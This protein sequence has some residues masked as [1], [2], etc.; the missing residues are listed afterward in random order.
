[1]KGARGGRGIRPPVTRPP[2][3]L[4]RGFDPD[5]PTADPG[6]GWSSSPRGTGHPSLQLHS[7]RHARE[8]QPS[9]NTGK[10]RGAGR[11]ARGRG[12]RRSVR[13]AR[14]RAPGGPLCPAPPLSRLAESSPAE[15]PARSGSVPQSSPASGLLPSPP[16]AEGAGGCQLPRAA[17]ACSPSPPVFR[18]EK[19]V[20]PSSSS[21]PEPWGFFLLSASGRWLEGTP[22]HPRGPGDSLVRWGRAAGAWVADADSPGEHRTSIGP[23]IPRPMDSSPELGSSHPPPPRSGPSGFTRRLGAPGRGGGWSC[24]NFPFTVFPPAR[25]RS[26]CL[27][28]V[29]TWDFCPLC[30]RAAGV[31]G[32]PQSLLYFERLLYIWLLS[33]ESPGHSREAQR[34]DG[35]TEGSVLL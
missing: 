19:V 3:T 34:S 27:R 25:L 11:G 15:S 30:G 7:L 17:W 20:A 23:L 24:G 5:P 9:W 21:L 4:P 29:E 26:C 1:M 18:W 32:G 16:E 31:L 10:A 33:R 22:S 14:C 35:E 12:C 13:D 2:R 28:S 6:S 8:K